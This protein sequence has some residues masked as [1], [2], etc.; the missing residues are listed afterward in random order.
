MLLDLGFEYFCLLGMD[1][2]DW[3]KMVVGCGGGFGLLFVI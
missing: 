2:V 1:F 3:L